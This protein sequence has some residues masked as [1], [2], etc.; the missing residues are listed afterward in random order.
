MSG[1]TT[2]LKAPSRK[3]ERVIVT[4]AGS[5]TCFVSGS[6]EVF[7]G[8][9]K[10]DYYN[11]MDSNRFEAWFLHLLDHIEPKSVIIIDND[12]CYNRKTQPVLTSATKKGKITQW[13]SSKNLV[14]VT[15]KGKKTF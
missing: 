5:D 3:G 12:P 2:G 13:L 6:L 14:H 4:Q 11:E 15:V 10:G 8:K 1:L 9:K 7:R